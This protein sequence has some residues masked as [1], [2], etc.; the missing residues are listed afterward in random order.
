LALGVFIA[1]LV[2]YFVTRFA[3][4]QFTAAGLTSVVA[5]VAGGV[6]EVFLDD[7]AK[8]GSIPSQAHW[9]YPIGLVLGFL[10]YEIVYTVIHRRPAA[11]RALI[12]SGRT[13]A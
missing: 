8:A 6:V 7:G 11:F 13:E 4:T 3:S 5:V 12:E 10:A 1:Y 2:W 9:W